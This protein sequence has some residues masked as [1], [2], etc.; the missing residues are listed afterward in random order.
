M[1][2]AGMYVSYMTAK[3]TYVYASCLLAVDYSVN[4]AETTR[5]LLA[6]ARCM[7][8][9]VPARSGS[10]AALSDSPG[11][12]CPCRHHLVVTCSC[13]P[14]GKSQLHMITH[15]IVSGQLMTSEMQAGVRLPLIWQP[16]KCAE[17]IEHCPSRQT[18]PPYAC[19]HTY[20]FVHPCNAIGKSEW[21]DGCGTC[22]RILFCQIW[23]CEEIQVHL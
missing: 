5:K 11:N 3:Y 8:S 21:R 6:L 20:A 10:A 9:G 16:S 7:K 4:S 23:S 15:H 14:A 13:M 22:D 18:V 17:Q 19:M 1:Y 12:R 2:I